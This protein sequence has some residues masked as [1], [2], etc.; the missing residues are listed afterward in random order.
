MIYAATSFVCNGFCEHYWKTTRHRECFTW[1]HHHSLE[2][3]H[4]SIEWKP[5]CSLWL[6]KFKMGIFA[7]KVMSTVFWDHKGVLLVDIME[8]STTVNAVSNCAAL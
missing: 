1:V 7:G 6:K 3:Q 8:K 4:A 2:T 5:P